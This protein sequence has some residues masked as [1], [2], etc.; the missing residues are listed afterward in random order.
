MESPVGQWIKPW[1]RVVFGLFRGL[2]LRS[3]A[4]GICALV[5]WAG[6]KAGGRPSDEDWQQEKRC[7]SGTD[8]MPRIVIQRAN[9]EFY[10]DSQN[11]SGEVEVRDATSWPR[12]GTHSF[13]TLSMT[14]RISPCTWACQGILRCLSMRERST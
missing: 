4:C 13:C 12:G 2:V 3:V 7:S 14:P 1:Q 9:E 8:P 5:V 11:L 10:W 6:C